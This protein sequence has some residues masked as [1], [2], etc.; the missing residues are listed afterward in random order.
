[1]RIISFITQ[2]LVNYNV[3]K[4]KAMLKEL[5][6]LDRSQPMNSVPFGIEKERSAIKFA[7]SAVRKTLKTYETTLDEDMKLLEDQYYKKITLTYPEYTAIVVRSS[8]KR[9]LIRLLDQLE[10]YGYFLSQA[11]NQEIIIS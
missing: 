2:D 3:R 1:M 9:I 5:E 7:S 10:Q 6:T 4:I 8:E 11:N